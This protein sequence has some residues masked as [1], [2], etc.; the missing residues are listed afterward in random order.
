MKYIV[1]SINFFSVVRI[2][3]ILFFLLGILI[4]IIYLM[5]FGLPAVERSILFSPLFGSMGVVEAILF[6]V[7]FA[8][9]F[10]AFMAVFAGVAALLY[11]LASNVMGGLRLCLKTENLLDTENVTQIKTPPIDLAQLPPEPQTDL[12]P[13]Q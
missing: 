9:A 11:N 12:Q 8:V 7:S 4:D 6:L 2:F 10:G 3:F 1:R 13:K 5:I